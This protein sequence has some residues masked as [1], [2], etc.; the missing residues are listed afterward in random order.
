MVSQAL[1]GNIS[2]GGVSIKKS[3]CT[4]MTVSVWVGHQEEHLALPQIIMTRDSLSGRSHLALCEIQPSHAS[5][6]L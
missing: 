4:W 1:N 6:W 3:L 5:T 2:R